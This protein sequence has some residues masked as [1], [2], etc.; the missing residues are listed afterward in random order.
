[1]PE[2]KS[3]TLRRDS[4]GPLLPI[5]GSDGTPYEITKQQAGNWLQNHPDA[6][7]REIKEALERPA[8]LQ[9]RKPLF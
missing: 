5:I 6:T 3:L 4:V 2:I 8:V 7:P 1:M 9:P